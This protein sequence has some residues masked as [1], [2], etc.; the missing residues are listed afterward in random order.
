MKKLLL[1]S[2]GIFLGF[3]ATVYG[4]T[5]TAAANITQTGNP[6]EIE[7][8]DQ[9]SVSSGGAFTSYVKLYTL[10]NYNYY[11]GIAL[12]PSTTTANYTF[13]DNGNYYYAVVVIDTANQCYDST[14]GTLSITSVATCNAGVNIT[15]SGTGNL[16]EIELTD[17]STVSSG[18]MYFST[19][20]FYELP[21]YNYVGSVDLQPYTNTATYQFSN[22]GN[23]YYYVEVT[24]STTQCYDTTGGN[25]TISGLPANCSSNYSYTINSSNP[26]EYFFTATGNTNYG[27]YYFWD[28][29]D[30]TYG[31]NSSEYHTYSNAGTY[32][33]C[34]TME[35]SVTGCIDT[36]CQNITVSAPINC[37]AGFYIF[38]D[39]MNAGQI[40]AWNLS[41]GS[42]LSYSWDF[43][44][45][46]TSNQAY[47]THTYSN[48]GNY[49][50]CLTVSDSSGCS[51]TF[52]DTI[53]ITS[54]ANGTTLNVLNPFV[55]AGIEDKTNNSFQNLSVYPNPTKSDFTMEVTTQTSASYDLQLTNLTGAIV[56]QK[57]F[58]VT[59][60]TSRVSLPADKLANGVYVLSIRDMNS[61]ERKVVKLIKQ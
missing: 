26:Y 56:L 42:N 23:Y 17:Q 41:N 43:G 14:G 38:Q 9:S 21:N 60:G 61:N 31:Y 59:K 30:G 19:V 36:L 25:I 53:A 18:G 32:S 28:F 16:G 58:N 50:I 6:G 8:I 15:Q 33:V 13:N 12:Q 49:T 35:D 48:I 34:L 47:P 4:Q 55:T 24:D 20:H 22:N 40:Y 57:S 7:V 11:G 1:L 46:S 10:P 39:S 52:C 3:S 29:G 51:D 44:D 2:I 5:C 37:G 45:G 54:K 27:S